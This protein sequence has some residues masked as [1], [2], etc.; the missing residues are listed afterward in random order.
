MNRAASF[1]GRSQLPS[2]EWPNDEFTGV[3]FATALLNYRMYGQ[4]FPVLALALFN[5]HLLKKR[6][7]TETRC[8]H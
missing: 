2:G 5:R 3:F 1:L 6:S 8:N 7:V 4:Y